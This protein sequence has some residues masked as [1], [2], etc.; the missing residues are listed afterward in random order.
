METKDG[1]RLSIAQIAE[2]IDSP[3]PFTAKILQTLAKHSFVSSA[4]GPGGGFYIEPDADPIV[5]MDIVELID[6][7]GAFERCGLGLKECD[8]SHPCPIH[9][10]FVSYSTR[11]KKLLETKTIQEFAKEIKKGNAFLMNA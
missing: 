7:K 8:A 5:V 3:E 9:N 4:K 6:G 10:E 1:S 2:A 11:L